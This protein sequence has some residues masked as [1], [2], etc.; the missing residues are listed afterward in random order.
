MRRL[1]RDPGLT[2]FIVYVMILAIVAMVSLI[3]ILNIMEKVPVNSDKISV[4]Y[5]QNGSM[6]HNITCTA[7]D[8]KG[9]AY[10]DTY[11][12]PKYLEVMVMKNGKPYSGVWITM[13]GCGITSEAA[14]T[15]S[16]GYAQFNLNGVHLD[17]G[18]DKSALDF[19]INGKIYH[20][21]VVRG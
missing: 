16:H 3:L 17:P 20:L 13:S 9:Y 5:Y 14:K 19:K 4:T 11:N 2:S 18:V 6:I 12:Y 10:Y 21:E 15:D 1:Y 7:I 8:E